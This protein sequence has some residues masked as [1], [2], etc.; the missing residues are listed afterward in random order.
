MKVTSVRARLLLWNI[1]ILT[2]ILFGFLLATHFAVRGY[3]L[4]SI[5]RRLEGMGRWQ[6][7]MFEHLDDENRPPPPPPR[8]DD[9]ERRGANRILRMMRYF[10]L[11]GQSITPAGEPTSE[12]V[13]PFDRAAFTRAAA[14]ASLYSFARNE[15]G[16][17]RVLTRPLLRDEQQV[18]VMQLA[19]S[20]TEAKVILDSLT[21]MLLLLVPCALV[22][23]GLGGYFLTRHTLRPI[24][25]I[26]D[27]A[28]ALNPDDL[29]QR[30]P[31]VG[32]DEFAHLA[33][34]MNGMLGRLEGAF[35]RLMESIERERRFTADAS[36]E[37]RT[38]LTAIKANTSLAL[39]GERAP[40][41]YREALQA[42]NT[43]ADSMTR[44]VQDLLLLARSDSN[45]LALTCQGVDPR[46][47]FREAVAVTRRKKGHAPV[48]VDVAED[49]RTVYGDQ[50]HL[51]RLVNNL[52]ENALRHTP[53]DGRITLEARRQQ[54]AVVLTVADTG[55]GIAPEHLA[56][57]GE[58][59]FRADPSRARQ[60]GGTGLGLAICRSI[61]DAHH[62]A[63]TIDST[64][65]EGTCVT[66]VLTATPP[67][68]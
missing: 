39:R 30:L 61:V 29:S 20:F 37:L 19:V 16:P 67:I 62:G 11:D 55:E 18:G 54:D 35:A 43:A 44:L 40:E 64:P 49:V 32:A 15:D 42:V 45:Q 28:E 63:M 68:G 58:R 5:D 66:V 23:A 3:L 7:R 9:R 22:V 33:V 14:G 27:A 59:F 12:P 34:T 48:L 51:Q 38:P 4:T 60:H 56:H 57:L 31:V 17:V 25:Q 46:D 41:Q 1:G 26:V 47:L 21:L 8:G 10:D 52:L 65:G 24:R 36:H 53:A 50:Q 2:A 13:A 6:V